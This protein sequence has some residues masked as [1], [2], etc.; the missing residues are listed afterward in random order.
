MCESCDEEDMRGGAEPLVVTEALVE[1]TRKIEAE[2]AGTRV[3]DDLWPI[4]FGARGGSID[5]Q[6]FERMARSREAALERVSAETGSGA[7]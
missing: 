2:M 5:W 7:Q 1:W 4:F 3:P 6:N